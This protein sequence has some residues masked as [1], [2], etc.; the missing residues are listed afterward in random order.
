[1]D[2]YT[3]GENNGITLRKEIIY[4]KKNKFIN[5]IILNIPKKYIEMI[6]NFSHSTSI[7]ILMLSL[8]CK[9]N[10][11]CIELLLKNG[12]DPNLEFKSSTS[13]VFVKDSTPFMIESQFGSAEI[14]DLM[15]SYGANIYKKDVLGNDSL[16]YAIKS[17]NKTIVKK[18]KKKR[19]KD[20]NR[21]R[22]TLYE[23]S[24]L[25]IDCIRKIVSFCF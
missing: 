2:F 20:Y 22:N 25:H 9:R 11:A 1:M 5:D 23:V 10:K 15:I 19:R 18:L 3:F 8:S 21:I 7:N 6:L 14:I 4:N 17:N 12:A 13:E 16:D 24:N